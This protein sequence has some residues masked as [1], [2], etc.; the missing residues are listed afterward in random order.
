ML[1]IIPTMEKS[2][3]LVWSWGQAS[4]SREWTIE[5][6]ALFSLWARARIWSSTCIRLLPISTNTS[7]NWHKHKSYCKMIVM[8]GDSIAHISTWACIPILKIPWN[9]SDLSQLSDIFHEPL[10]HLCHV[11]HIHWVSEPCSLQGVCA[12][13][14]GH[15]DSIGCIDGPL[16]SK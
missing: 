9:A 3:A 16:E 11:Q 7:D 6:Q 5:L 10:H 4:F 15:S 8:S 13:L 2:W 12:H 14:V 1:K